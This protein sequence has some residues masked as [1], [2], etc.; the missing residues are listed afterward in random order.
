MRHPQAFGK[1]TRKTCWFRG[2]IKVF[3]FRTGLVTIEPGTDNS[4]EENGFV[5]VKEDGKEMA[6]Y[7]L[8]GE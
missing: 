3:K 8:W 6:V 2:Q 1:T 7:H 4:I 5:V